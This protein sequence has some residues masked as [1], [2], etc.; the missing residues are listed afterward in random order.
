MWWLSLVV[1]AMAL[2]GT[3]REAV[4]WGIAIFVLV[5][6]GAIAG[7]T[8]QMPGT[9][10]ETQLERDAALVVY[11]LVLFIIAWG[12]RKVVES[13]SMALSRAREAAQE[14]SEAKS[15]FMAHMSHELRTP[16]NG[17]IAMTDLVLRS[18]VTERIACV[19]RLITL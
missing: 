10:G 11:M 5:V 7:D 18:G 17:I 4:G 13:R 15:R 16:L 8:L 3:R 6:F 14:S 12:F 9:A 1:F 2:L 19:V